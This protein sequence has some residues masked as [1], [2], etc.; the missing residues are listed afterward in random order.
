[1]GDVKAFKNKDPKLANHVQTVAD[2]FNIFG[3][4]S[5]VNYL[6]I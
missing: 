3:W 1:V 4:F 6:H 5:T 2:G